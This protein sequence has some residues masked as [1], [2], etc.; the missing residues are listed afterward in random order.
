MIVFPN[1]KINLGLRVVNKRS[2]GFH[3]LQ[4]VFFPLPL[5]DALEIIEAPTGT[6]NTLTLSGIFIEGSSID[7][8]CRKAY[9]LLKTDFPSLPAVSMHLHKNI[10]ISAGLGGGSADGAFTLQ[11]LNKKFQLQLSAEKL[12][13]YALAL[14]SDCPFFLHNQP[15]YATARGEVLQ[16]LNLDLSAYTLV[17]VNPGIAIN[18][19]WAFQNVSPDPP[20]TDLRQMVLQAVETW[21]ENIKND[22]EKPVF[23]TYPEIKT[24]RDKLYEAGALF[25]SL[26]GSGSTVFGIFSGTPV[27]PDFPRHYFVKVF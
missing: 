21:K 10:P 20:A 6:K 9:E 7:N 14:G 26:S 16:P 12:A 11:L 3:N 15:C 13:A 24:I 23:A 1:C 8:I 18:T 27:L 17:I 22:F 19:A 4:T 25:A 5:Q 2:D